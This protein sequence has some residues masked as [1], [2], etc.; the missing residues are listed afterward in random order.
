[1]SRL[2]GTGISEEMRQLASLFPW[3][4]FTPVQ[5]PTGTDP[6]RITKDSELPQLIIQVNSTVTRPGAV[7]GATRAFHGMTIFVVFEY[8]DDDDIGLKKLQIGEEIFDFLC[9]NKHGTTYKMFVTEGNSQGAPMLDYEP[10]E[11][12]AYA[13]SGDHLAAVKITFAVEQIPMFTIN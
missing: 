12:K 3:V 10:E 13:A 4:T 1:M 9:I 6:R 11:E 2:N 5:I 7:G 8:V